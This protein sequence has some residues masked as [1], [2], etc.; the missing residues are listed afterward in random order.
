MTPSEELWI[1][2]DESQAPSAGAA[3]KGK[4]FRIG[5]LAASVSIEDEVSQ[6]ALS[7]L[8]D[9]PDTRGN[10]K[11]KATLSRRYFHA[12]A[13]SPNAHSHI[14]RAI[15]AHA[16]NGEFHDFQW[17]FGRQ[18]QVQLT[19]AQLHREALSLALIPYL[20]DGYT[21]IHLIIAERRG[22]F[23]KHDVDG[24]LVKQ[25]E[26][27][28]AAFA[29]HPDIPSRFPQIVPEVTTGAHPGVQ[30]CDFMLWAVQRAD[31]RVDGSCHGNSDWCS[32]VSLRRSTASEDQG[33]PMTDSTFVLN[34]GLVPPP[35]TY[36]DWQ[37]L[38]EPGQSYGPRD[39][40]PAIHEIEALVEK[41]F[42]EASRGNARIVHHLDR[43]LPAASALRG[44]LSN[45][46]VR[47]IG[48]A[49]LL[50]CDTFPLYDGGSSEARRR[51]S[52]LRRVVGLALD[53]SMI[54]WLQMSRR[55]REAH[56]Q[57]HHLI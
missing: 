18:G 49:F 30:V 5:V 36:L 40:E 38:P 42:Q 54:N 8:D 7:A 11:D 35:H 56:S 1:Y 53:R 28:L 55:W 3:E 22:S 43:L 10:V 48:N 13:D 12:S 14:A 21:K 39:L 24:W 20:Q 4:P 44:E 47:T 41:A 25:E 52:E 57:R 27:R 6:R 16:I 51:M 15:Q 9:D 45:E 17:H 26:M 33:S 50:V 23:F 34:D 31:Y 19:E 29:T 2:V 46:D 32:R 37:D